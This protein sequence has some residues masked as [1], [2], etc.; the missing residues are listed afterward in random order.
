MSRRFI[1][2]LG[3]GETIEETFVASEKQLRPNR[4]GNLYLQLRLADRSGTVSAM[5]WNAGERAYRN[6]ENGDYVLVSGTTQIY[7][8]KLQIIVSDIGRA[9]PS[10]IEMDDFQRLDSSKVDQ[11]LR[12]LT[13]M[14]RG[15]KDSNLRDLAESF[16]ADQEFIDRFSRC[17]AGVKNHHA[18]VGGLLEHVV[19]LMEIC[20]L[21]G[22]RYP[23]VN[24][25][26][27]LMGAFLHDSGKIDE[28]C[29]DR[30]LG[31]TDEG[32]LIG[33]LVIAVGYV[34]AKIHE[35]E[36]MSKEPFPAHLALRLKHMIVSHHGQ[37]EF[38]S[39]KLPM[40]LEAIALHQLD[41]LDAK[42]HSFRQII[43]EDANP[44]GNWTVYQATL[45]RKLYKGP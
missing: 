9:D 29:Y 28:L 45:G 10:E 5:M 4:N 33:H 20:L 43:E 2:Q 35:L 3:D 36:L 17:P 12:R 7:N 25:D 39:P 22:P 27:L 42:L 13:D 21:V 19:N 32:Q 14:L 40:T 16:L 24:L 37:Y 8:G 1:N 6:F 15:M 30:D 18:Y 34:D 31:Y 44:D 23:E 41:D 11:L 26:L 38:G